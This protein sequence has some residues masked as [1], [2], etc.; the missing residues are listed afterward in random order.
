LPIL[1]FY[2]SQGSAVTSVRCGG[3]YDIDFITHFM[4]NTT[5]KEVSK[6]TNVRGGYERMYSDTAFYFLYTPCLSCSVFYL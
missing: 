6:S 5:V 2:I 4:K 1:F 3:K